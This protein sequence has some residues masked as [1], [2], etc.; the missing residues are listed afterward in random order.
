VVVK[1]RGDKLTTS[2]KKVLRVNV[3]R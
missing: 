2:K 3:T 1:Y